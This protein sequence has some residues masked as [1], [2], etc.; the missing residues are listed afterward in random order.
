MQSNPLLVAILLK[1]EEEES[2][3]Y[4]RIPLLF[5]RNNEPETIADNDVF[6][7][8]DDNDKTLDTLDGISREQYEDIAI[9]IDTVNINFKIIL[10]RDAPD[11]FFSC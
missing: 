11:A 7:Q 9:C 10:F 2:P 1:G 6:D 8:C 4:Y 3:R 5:Q